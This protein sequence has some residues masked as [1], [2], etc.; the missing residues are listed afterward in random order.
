[1]RVLLKAEHSGS[2]KDQSRARQMVA[3]M[4]HSM[5]LLKGCLR[6]PDLAR[7]MG[8]VKEDQLEVQRARRMAHQRVR[9]R[10]RRK[11]HPMVPQTAVPMVDLRV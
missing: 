11:V 5:E 6:G 1:M 4:G 10:A 9:Q 2:T 8:S 7:L 3:K